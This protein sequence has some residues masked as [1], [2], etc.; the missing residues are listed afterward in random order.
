MFTRLLP[1]P[2]SSLAFFGG[3]QCLP[4]RVNVKRFKGSRS[5]PILVDRHFY[6]DAETFADAPEA[7]R[8]CLVVSVGAHRRLSYKEEGHGPWFQLKLAS[9]E[10]VSF[11]TPG[12]HVP[13]RAAFSHKGA[14]FRSPRRSVTNSCWEAGL[15]AARGGAL[16]QSAETRQV[17]P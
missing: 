14:G 9:T 7:R 10:Y 8:R 1:T 6:L 11:E 15:G 4:K 17:H 5:R 3:C 12:K 2:A 13:C 16:E